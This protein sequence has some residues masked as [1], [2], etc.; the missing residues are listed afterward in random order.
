MEDFASTIVVSM[1]RHALKQQGIAISGPQP[2]RG[3]TVTVEDKRSL[4]DAAH[5]VGGPLAILRVA[6]AIPDFAGHP[7]ARVFASARSG[8]Q[9]IE[10]W[11]RLERYFHSRNRSR[12][13][14]TAADLVVMEHFDSR[15]GQTVTGEDLIVA[16]IILGLM[17]WAGAHDVKLIFESVDNDTV[18][19]WLAYE[20]ERYYPP[21]NSGWCSQ[22]WR[23]RWGSFQGKSATDI[24]APAVPRVTADGRS[25]DNELVSDLYSTI[26]SDP[27]AH[28]SL[29]DQ[30]QAFGLSC[31]TLQRRLHEAGWSLR[32][33]TASAR[34]DVAARLLAETDMPIALVGLLAGFSDQPHFQREFAKGLGPTPGVFRELAITHRSSLRAG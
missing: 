7:I 31:R 24:A 29:S 22:R 23:L 4:L 3:R 6:E 12:L 10:A 30:A 27:G 9:V 14:S 2:K 32:Q 11:L 33:I 8:V 5:D 21:P 20:S 13:H 16:G 17:R 15:G 25:I 28:R 19:D 1:L 34:L 26:A 18:G